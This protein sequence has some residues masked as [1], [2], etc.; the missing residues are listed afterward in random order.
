MKG[1]LTIVLVSVFSFVGWSQ[2]TL[3]PSGGNQK[4]VVTQYIGP[5]AHVTIMYNSPDVTASNGDDRKGKIWGQLVP[6]GFTKQGF[7]LNNPAPWRAG[8]NENT[9]IKFS[10]DVLIEGQELKAGKYAFFIAPAE[11]GPWTVVFSNNYSGWGSYFYEEKDDAL[12]V[13][14]DPKECEYT[15]WLTYE[16]VDRQP[17]AATFALKWE[18]ISVPIKLEV[19]N[20]NDLIVEN[21]KKELIGQKGFSWTNVNAAANFCLQNNTHL[22]QGLVWAEQAISAPF[23]GNENF[24]TLFTKAQLLQRLEKGGDAMEVMEKAAKHPTATVLQVHNCGRTLIGMGKKEKA[25]EMF[26]YNMERFG[27][28]WPVRVG[29]ARGLAANGK[30]DEAIK[31]AKI[32]FE[33]APDSLNK[34][35]LKAAIEKLE[36]GEDI[37]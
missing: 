9:I 33:R 24:T 7:G 37:N 4:S 13:E 12:R 32:A 27:D 36:K 6:Y 19:P 26:E 14:V 28:V 22:E 20:N 25:L 30:Y 1:I 15:E 18:N 11:Q 23:I 35:S 21:L 29:M 8:A 5:L 2:I 17:N 31:H 34:N 16:F 3:P 10:H